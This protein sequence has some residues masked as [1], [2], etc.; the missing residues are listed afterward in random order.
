MIRSRVG[1]P[2]VRN[3]YTGSTEAFRERVRNERCVELAYESNHYWFDIR[4]WKIAPELMTRTLEGMMVETCTPDEEHPL[5]KK[6]T[7]RALSSFRQGVWKD[8]MYV[9]PFSHNEEITM[10]EFKNNAP[11]H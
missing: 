5:G 1:M 10:T 2:N 9:L 8:C 4:R 3:T 7:R 6:Y 11:W